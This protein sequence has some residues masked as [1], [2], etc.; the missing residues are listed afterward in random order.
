MEMGT[1]IDIV[2]GTGSYKKLKIRTFVCSFSVSYKKYVKI[3][4]DI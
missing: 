1:R 4:V 2:T 3:H